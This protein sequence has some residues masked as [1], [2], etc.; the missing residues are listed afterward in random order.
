MKKKFVSS[1]QPA[2][3]VKGNSRWYLNIYYT[4]D[5]GIKV[6]AKPTFNL[7]RILNLQERHRRGK[8]LE[9][10]L[11]WWMS[12]GLGMPFEENK[13]PGNY[14]IALGINRPAKYDTN[15]I[16]AFRKMVEIKC[17]EDR[18]DS[19]R[20]YRSILQLF[21]AFLKKYGYES[22]CVADIDK[23]IA[24]EYLDHI[25]IDRKVGNRTYN[26]DLSKLRSFFKML[27]TRSYI[28][29]NPFEGFERKKLRKKQ[30]RNFTLKEAQIVVKEMALVDK[31]L[32]QAFILQYCCFIRPTE[33]R[34][35]KFKDVD[36]KNG[37]IYLSEDQAKTKTE[38][39]ATIPDSF[40][41]LLD[42]SFF[43]S[44]PEHFVI[45]GSHFKPHPTKMCGRNEMNR[46]HRVILEDLVTRG[47]LTDITGISWYSWKDTG[48]TDALYEIDP[49]S[50]QD[51]AGHSSL[52]MTMRYKHKRVENEAIRSGFSNKLM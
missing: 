30:R 11:T 20:S 14:E 40:A 41:H 17:N 36:F 19:N 4:D 3:L 43:E 15:V 26:N 22:L 23:S 33:M 37:L 46:R 8:E 44:F 10:K 32:F 6:Q 2:R 16:E 47:E 49:S 5:N 13:V 31:L 52:E 18:E 21:T 45:F 38:R 48:I 28:G 42:R 27:L 12:R 34:R 35:L 25:Q 9:K 7:N 29:E 39:V 51:Q 50:V 24:A 1:Y